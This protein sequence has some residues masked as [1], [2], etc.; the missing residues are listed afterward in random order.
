[1]KLNI[2]KKEE[3]KQAPKKVKNT[4]TLD[5]VPQEQVASAAFSGT[6]SVISQI[7]TS[8][9]STRLI[10]SNQYVFKVTTNATKNEIKKE[11]GQRFNV[12]VKGVRVINIRGKKRMLGRHPGFRSGYRKAVVILQPGNVIQ[13][14]KP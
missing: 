10:A 12:K 11:V 7:Y 3:K 9:K 13:Q 4:E 14:A 8:E 2:F 1:M 5:V 6:N